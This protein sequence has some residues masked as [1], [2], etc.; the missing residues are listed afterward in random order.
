MRC[1]LCGSES[2]FD[3]SMC[4]E[5]TVRELPKLSIDTTREVDRCGTCMRYSVPPSGWTTLRFEGPEMLAYL[6]KKVPELARM[7]LVD[8]YFIHS[9]EHSKRV[10]MR[11]S[12]D[13]T[14]ELNMCSV[15]YSQEL[16]IMW[17]IKGKHCL[18]CARAASNQTWN[19]VVQLRQKSELKQTLLLLEQSIL[20][21]GLHEECTDIKGEQDG[22]DFFYMSR[23]ACLKLVRF[24]EESVP[25]KVKSSE[26]LVKLDKKSNNSR[27]K[28]AYSVEIPA[29]N[30]ND[31][32]YVPVPLCKKLSLTEMCIVLRISKSVLLADS[33]GQVKDLSRIDYFKYSKSIRVLGSSKAQSKFE[34][35][36][37][38]G[39]HKPSKSTQTT[40]GHTRS[41]NSSGINNDQGHTRSNSGI[42]NISTSSG[43]SSTSGI[44]SI[45]NDQGHT[46]S[47][48]RGIHLNFG[49][50]MVYD[51]LLLKS[52]GELVNTKTLVKGLVPGDSVVGYDLMNLNTNLDIEGSIVL[53]KKESEITSKWKIKRICGG[54]QTES[55]SA[56]II[57]AVR[58]DPSLLK[59]VNIY[60]E[61]NQLIKGI[62]H[63]T[64]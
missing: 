24:I 23:T 44:S 42:S 45:S 26:Q 16:E 54:Y 53:L 20:K 39:Y 49:R 8:A 43:I 2:M 55:T 5:C 62:K 21:A 40:Q 50:N 64:L 15:E 57:D 18:D 34:V 28:F 6:L 14:G 19:C 29:L 35:V 59:T 27:Y 37:V 4:Y 13:R 9:E 58:N 47:G 31:L 17:V 36:E 30:L 7:K 56:M 32:L 1:C 33:K 60:D 11:I 48:T 41:N 61:N 25:T 12:I 63:L 51:V 52:D 46:S 10:R 38:D 22:I 3:T